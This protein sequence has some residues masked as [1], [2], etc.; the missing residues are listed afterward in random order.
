MTL[1]IETHQLTRFFDR[2]CAV[3]GIELRVECGTFYGFLGPN[4][5]GKSTTIKMLTGLLAPT[6]GQV[7]VLGKDM[8]DPRA[9]LEVKSRMGVIPEDLALFDNL[10]AREYLTFIGRMYLLPRD[11]I[12]SRIGELLPMLGLENEEKKLTLEYSHGM[13]KKLALAAA[14]LPNP[15]LLFLDEPFEGVDAVTSRV[16]RDML[17]GYVARG[18]TVF[19]TSHVLEIVERLCTHVGIIVKGRLVEQA[20]LDAIRQGGSL[21]DRFLE[22]AGGDYDVTRKLSWLEEGP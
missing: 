18:S 14:L 3:D 11:T 1:A 6:R 21:E 19:L 2:F 13:K 10:T 4:G 9:A 17:S 7:L 15:D 20:S 16:V 5:A 12:R 22:R 8:L